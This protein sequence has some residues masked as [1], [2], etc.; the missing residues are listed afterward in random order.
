M[1]LACAR[2]TLPSVSAWWPC[3]VAEKGGEGALHSCAGGMIGIVGSADDCLPFGKLF[4]R[5][6]TATVQ[7]LEAC[8]RADHVQLQLCA[9]NGAAGFRRARA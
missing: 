4:G 2:F 6:C 1:L 5:P 8:A 3:P 7:D 9:E